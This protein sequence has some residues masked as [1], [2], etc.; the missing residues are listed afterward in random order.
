M[1]GPTERQQKLMRFIHE[2]TRDEGYPPT[3]REMARS[4]GAVSPTAALDHL[5][6]L[7]RKGLVRRRA[8]VSR[9]TAL[10]AEGQCLVRDI[11]LRSQLG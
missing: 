4:L 7:V 10:T 6:S 3:L 11:S 8:N 1:K 9:G 5:N 2:F